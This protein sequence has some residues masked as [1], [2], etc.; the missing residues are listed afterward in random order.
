MYSA[1]VYYYYYLFI[2]SWSYHLFIYSWSENLESFLGT[3]PWW[4]TKV[5]CL[6]SEN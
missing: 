4:N 1:E 6:H 3:H 2:Y 5:S